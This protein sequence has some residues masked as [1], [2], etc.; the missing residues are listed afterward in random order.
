MRCCKK[1]SKIKDVDEFQLTDKVTGSR[2]HVC[3]DCRREKHREWCNNNKDRVKE[4]S[5]KYSRN[6]RGKVLAY[7]RKYRK[8]KRGF[9]STT[10][11]NMSSRVQGKSKPWLYKG[12][13]ICDRYD[14]IDW[15]IKDRMFNMLFDEWER[16]GY[17]MKLT[18]S[19]DR[20]DSN[21]GYIFSNMSWITHSENSQRGA[22]SRW[23]FE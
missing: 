23:G 6:N 21:N 22:F 11:T 16:S 18:P 8:T 15:S 13:P 4:H 9:L 2:R 10:F 19:I 14:F 3:K 5:K 7:S 1:C 20:I 12:L 17:D